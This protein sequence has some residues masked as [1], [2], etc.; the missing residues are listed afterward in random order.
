V[1]CPAAFASATLLW[2]KRAAL[3]PIV[4]PGG[5]QPARFGF[6]AVQDAIQ[7]RLRKLLHRCVLLEELMKRLLIGVEIVRWW[8]ECHRDLF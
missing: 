8:A 2:T 6:D 7:Q 3:R 4:V 1:R 5:A